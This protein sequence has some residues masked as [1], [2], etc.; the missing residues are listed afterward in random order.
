MMKTD[1]VTIYKKT[2][3]EDV[4][5]WTK[6]VVHGVQWSD[7]VDK[8]TTTGRVSRKPYAS[9]TFFIDS[10]IY[11]LNS[12]GEEDIIVYG[13]CEAVVSTTK[14]SRPSDVVEANVKS[15]FITSVNDNT[16]RDHLKNMKVVV[17]RG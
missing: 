14:G 15:G 17:S 1:T 5:S 10:D 3:V 4:T 7:H 2:V 8:T 13:D 11:G 9:I 12:F 16:N 6:T